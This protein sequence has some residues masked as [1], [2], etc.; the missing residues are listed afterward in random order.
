MI[1]D[2]S[3]EIRRIFSTSRKES[4]LGPKH[5]KNG[6]PQLTSGLHQLEDTLCEK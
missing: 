1:T 5:T 4:G 2:K 6:F 3:A